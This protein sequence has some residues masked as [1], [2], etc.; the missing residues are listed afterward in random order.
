MLSDRPYMRD[1]YQRERTS[2]LIWLLSAIVAGF[3]VQNIFAVW[4]RSA[5]FHRVAELTADSLTSGWVWTLL[6]Y[7]LVHGGILH[8]LILGLSIFF[9]GRELLH[10][11]DERRM[12]WL[13]L[14]GVLA[15][16][17]A[18]FAVNFNRSGSLIGSAPILLCYLTV[19]ACMF[20]NRQISFLIFFII[21]VT[22]RPK[23]ILW[24]VLFF[25]VCGFIFSELPAS[26]ITGMA[27]SAHL[28][29]ILA[30]WLYHRYVHQADWLS[31]R[32]KAEMEL[33]RWMKR[34][35][36]PQPPAGA[37]P[38]Y[39][40]NVGKPEDLRAEVDRILDKINSEGFGA[41]TPEEKR[42]LDDARDSLSRH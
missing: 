28:G 16:G 18:W 31:V 17:L 3:V 41:L 32:R 19:F 11:L 13:T 10:H 29:A 6:T 34:A 25:D 8:L 39:R 22:T 36:K 42:L 21:P 38:T 7:P 15:G 5:S 40:V 27:H 37:A 9:I 14:A 20:P 2:F 26:G 33:P 30:G 4:L 23:Y 35:R 1:D 12:R 24:V